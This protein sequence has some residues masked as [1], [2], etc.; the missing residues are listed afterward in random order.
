MEDNIN[1][2]KLGKDSIEQPKKYIKKWRN[3]WF[4]DNDTII[5]DFVLAYGNIKDLFQR[6]KSKGIIL[7][8]DYFGSIGDTYAHFCTYN[9]AVALQEGFE[10]EEFK[11]EAFEEWND[12]PDKDIYHFEVNKFISLKLIEGKTLIFVHGERFDQCRYVLLVDPLRNEDQREIGSIDEVQAMYNNDLENE[13]TPEQLGISREQEFW[14]HSSNLQAWYENNYD[15]RLLHSNI[16]FPLL[17]KLAEVGDVKAKKVF[18]EEVAKRFASGYFPVMT[19]LFKEEYLDYL[20]PEEFS[21]LLDE[22]D[23]SKLDLSN[24]LINLSDFVFSN[25]TYQFLSRIKEEFHGYFS[26]NPIYID[27]AEYILDKSEFGPVVITPDSNYFIRGSNDGK[28]KE[29][30]IITG[31]LERVF[32]SHN[33]AIFA[34]AISDDG[35]YVAS[36][37]DSKIKIWDYA[38]GNLIYTLEGHQDVVNCLEFDPEG[39]YLVSGSVDMEIKVWSLESGKMKRTLGSHFKEINTLD[40]SKDGSY[41]VSGSSDTTV[42]LYDTTSSDLV[43]TFIDKEK[44]IQKVAISR[45]NSFIVIGSHSTLKIWDLNENKIIRTIHIPYE[46]YDLCSF[47]LTP[48]SEFI[49]GGLQGPLEEGGKLS[50]WRVAD[51]KLIHT[52][53]I[54]LGFRRY[55]EELNMI[56][57]SKDG[58]FIVGA[59]RDRIVKVWMDFLT[60]VELEGAFINSKKKFISK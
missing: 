50:M 27:I 54:H 4:I 56:T 34:L 52:I 2:T 55:S 15:T 35:T 44:I 11:V 46:K 41:L 28:L 45:L 13:I 9:E 19:Y 6:W 18:K 14:A 31:D 40:Y 38:S 21:T 26:E 39:R 7:D 36:S 25:H 8:P 24:L 48:D 59:A 49:V 57:I 43:L 53:P 37:C 42:N 17:K 20:T 47:V 32:G 58:V 3:E 51:G 29:F 12:D 5:D 60:Y 1:N 33:M 30:N 23:Y 16:S 22:V 10:E